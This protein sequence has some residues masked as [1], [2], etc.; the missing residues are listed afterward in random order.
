MA[1]NCKLVQ[2]GRSNIVDGHLKGAMSILSNQFPVTTDP[3]SAFLERVS[4]SAFLVLFHPNSVVNGELNSSAQAFRFYDVIAALSFGT[5]PLSSAPGQGCLAPFP[6]LDSRGVASSPGSVDS[7]LGMA[8]TLWPIIHQL[9]NLPGLKG[10]LDLAIEQGDISKTAVLRVEFEATT[11][12]I[13]IALQEWQPVLPVDCVLAKSID[14]VSLDKVAER[15]RLQGI[16]NN[17]LAYQHSALVYLYRTIY[18]HPRV[19]PLVQ[20]HT[21]LS[22]THC[23]GTVSNEGP[24]SALLWPLFVAACEARDL[25]DRELARR[26]FIA[27]DKRQGMINIERGWCIVQEVWR[28][29]DEAEVNGEDQL[30]EMARVMDSGKGALGRKG[31]QDLWRKVSEEMGV[32]IVLG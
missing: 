20:R 22:L 5:A 9:S 18:E 7:L 8:T 3:A 21:H 29:A 32:T 1:N 30:S 12:A 27:I 17:A 28:R 6:P 11:S 4:D 2:Q 26:A 23:V 24:M 15:R 31:K 10:E 16:L 19:H 25:T 13:D 14:E